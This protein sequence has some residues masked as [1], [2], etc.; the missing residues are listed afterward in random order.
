MAAIDAA[1]NQRTEM[2][3]FLKNPAIKEGK[4]AMIRSINYF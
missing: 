2:A 4:E 1:D 3:Y